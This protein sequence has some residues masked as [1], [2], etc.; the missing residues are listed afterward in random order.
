MIYSLIKVENTE[1]FKENTRKGKL[2]KDMK[3]RSTERLE[4]VSSNSIKPTSTNLIQNESK[5]MDIGV[6]TSDLP[7][8]NNQSSSAIAS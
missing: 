4:Q 1:D 5:Q 3:P 2:G 7:G 8:S 6:G